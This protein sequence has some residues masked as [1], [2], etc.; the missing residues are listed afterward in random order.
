MNKLRWKLTQFMSGRNGIDEWNQCLFLISVVLYV[1]SA[2]LR[3]PSVQL[4]AMFGMVY[5]LYRSFSKR[6]PE[7]QSEN[8]RFMNWV[9]LQKL[10]YEQRKEYKIYCCKSCGRRIRVPKGKGK[11]EVTC[12]ICGTKKIHRT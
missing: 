1:I 9:G 2:L 6:L 7:R 4:L 11:I 12:P 10:R 8:A 3:S 5:V